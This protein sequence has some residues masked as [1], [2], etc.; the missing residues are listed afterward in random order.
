MGNITKVDFVI[1]IE[2]FVILAIKTIIINY[3]KF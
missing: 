2:Y 3:F 1:I